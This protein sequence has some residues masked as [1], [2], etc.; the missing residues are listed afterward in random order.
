LSILSLL[1]F[2]VAGFL[3]LLRVDP[4]RAAA[5]ARGYTGENG[6]ALGRHS[7]S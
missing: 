2:F 6:H 4:E 3:V 7:Y 1:A 5:D